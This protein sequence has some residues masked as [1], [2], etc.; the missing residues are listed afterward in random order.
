M[1]TKEKIQ[2]SLWWSK[3]KKYLVD[4]KN[5]WKRGAFMVICYIFLVVYVCSGL[6]AVIGIFQFLSKLITG[7]T[8]Q[9]LISAGDYLSQHTWQILRFI[10]YSTESHPW[11][12]GPGEAMTSKPR[13]PRSGS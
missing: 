3:T 10:L 12:F 5:N 6:F 9:R 8:N 11:P 2:D 13:Q 1:A 7:K 4:H